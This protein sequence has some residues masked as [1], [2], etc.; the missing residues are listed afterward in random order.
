MGGTFGNSSGS[1]QF[2]GETL[3]SY[4]HLLLEVLFL[5]FRVRIQTACLL[6]TRWEIIIFKHPYKPKQ[7]MMLEKVMKVLMIRRILLCQRIV[8]KQKILLPFRL[9]KQNYL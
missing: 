7:R 3:G 8:N 5:D 6:M 2:G 4:S 1:F 9:V